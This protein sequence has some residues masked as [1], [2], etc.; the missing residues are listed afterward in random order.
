M[1][2]TQR[3]LK[4]QEWFHSDGFPIH[5][6]RRE[7]QEPFGLHAHD[8]TELVVVTAGRGGHV[9]GEEAWPLEAGDVF[10]IPQGLQ[11]DYH[12]LDDLRLVNLMFDADHL[13]M[14]L[15]DLPSLPG[16]HA[17]FSLEPAW[18]SR[19]QFRSRLRLNLEELA[20][21]REMIRRLEEELEERRT[22]F[23]FLAT[24]HFMRIVGHL[25]RHYSEGKAD[26]PHTRDLLRIGQAIAYL[27]RHF[28]E[29]VTLEQLAELAGMAK[30]SFQR[31]FRTATGL[32]PIAYLLRLRI[33]RAAELLRS[34][35]LTISEIGFRV[36]FDDSN[37]FSR[38]FRAA[39][40]VSP[41]EY[42]KRYDSVGRS[43]R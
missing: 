3:I 42:R 38:Q 17:L 37:Y 35:D 19:H 32:S 29:P 6:G 23:A 10:V 33:R 43:S 22:G 9:A 11:H 27:E 1:A 12:D 5:V 15:S 34:E 8:F 4:R 20:K 13:A 31:D 16:Y 26:N 24:A 36:G 18:R 30:R 7:P 40:G 14:P 25:S 39:M 41:R 2:M 28:D 21:V